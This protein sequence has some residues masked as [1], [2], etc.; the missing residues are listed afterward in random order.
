MSTRIRTYKELLAEKERLN[1]LV[2][3]QAQVIQ[4]DIADIK[5]ELKPLTNVGATIG[6]FFTRKSGSFITD[7]GINLLVNGFV[8][9]ILLSKTGWFTRF[10]IPKLLKNYASHLVA[11][12][13]KVVE[14]ILDLFS[15]NGKEDHAGMEAVSNQ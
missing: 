9:K 7:L 5:E 8:K 6:K 11:E 14:T 10:I 4:E 2:K 1:T 12:P 13:E 15:K 3:Y